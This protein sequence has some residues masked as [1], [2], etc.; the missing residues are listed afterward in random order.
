MPND[1]I[2]AADAGTLEVE[3]DVTQPPRKTYIVTSESGL[4]KNGKQ[5][6]PGDEIELDE[7][8]AANFLALEEV[9]AKDE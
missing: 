1:N 6:E 7:K 2:D 5:Y 3:R 4:F 8:T 9:E